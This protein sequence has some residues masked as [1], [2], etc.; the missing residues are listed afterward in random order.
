MIKNQKNKEIK[1]LKREAMILKGLMIVLSKIN[2]NSSLLFSISF[3]KITLSAEKS[4]AVVSIFSAFGKEIALNAIK[5]LL[6]Y[7]KQ[8]HSALCEHLQF[9]YMPKLKFIYDAQ[10]EKVIRIND[11]ISKVNKDN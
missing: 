3:T 11:L 7:Q 10:Y 9:R 8:I 6:S 4:T 1:T 5:L 2:I